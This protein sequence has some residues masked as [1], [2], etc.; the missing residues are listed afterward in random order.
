MPCGGNGY[1]ISINN[2]VFTDMKL[3]PKRKSGLKPLSKK[4]GRIDSSFLI[5]VLL[6]A[7]YGSI[8]VFSA[9]GPY[10][11]ARYGDGFYFVKKQTVWLIIGLTVMLV[12]SRIKVDVYRKFTPLLYVITVILLLLV[13]I[14][15]FVGNGAQR[16]I[17]IG[18]ITIQPS[19]IAK[20]SLILMLADYFH[21]FEEKAT[22]K[23]SKKHAFIYGT[24]I[25][26]IIMLIPIL[27]VML[28]K[29]LS[30]IIILGAIGLLLIFSA[31]VNP[32]YIGG[33]CVLGAGAVTYLALFTDYTK[34][35]ITVWRDPEAYK[36][37]GGWQTLQGL[38]AIGTGGLFGVGLGK[39][40][41]KHCYVSEPANDMIF[42][43]LCEELGFV[44]A[45]L[46]LILFALLILRGAKISTRTT[47][48]FSRLLS[49]GISIKMATQVLLNVAVVT[50]SI[51]NTG[52]S[53]PFF[54]Y[55][56]SS[57]VMLFFEMGIILSVSRET[58]ISK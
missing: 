41:L 45:A 10:A 19:E 17:S 3:Y 39:S 9:G 24:L 33:F 46:A 21:T 30:C 15:G 37:T 44:G 5:L 51:P 34:E 7:T 16:W 42:A 48:T 25:P 53:L 47:N 6:I 27:L 31:G 58:F 56:G 20:L 49:L 18:P 32:K 4:N 38:M 29:H 43:I 28:Q 8:M 40:V 35:R 50:N 54:S 57:L 52:I 2:G 13:L 26:S 36:L 1:V 14:F 22:D 12:S 23:K 55:G 11:A